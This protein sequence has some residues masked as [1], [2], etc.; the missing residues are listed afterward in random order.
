MLL[1]MAVL[2]KFFLVICLTKYSFAECPKSGTQ[3][4][5]PDVLNL[6]S[7][8]TGYE[9]W[10]EI[11]SE[12]GLV[13]LVKETYYEDN[14]KVEITVIKNGKETKI[15]HFISTGEIFMVSQEPCLTLPFDDK[16]KKMILENIYPARSLATELLVPL[17]GKIVSPAGLL[18]ALNTRK[19]GIF[20]EEKEEDKFYFCEDKYNVMVSFV[21]GNQPSYMTLEL[22]NRINQMTRI[23]VNYVLYQPRSEKSEFLTYPYQYNCAR[24]PTVDQPKFPEFPPFMP[25]KGD[26]YQYYMELEATYTKIINGREDSKSV[27]DRTRVALTEDNIGF[28]IL[29]LDSKL[30]RFVFDQNFKISYSIKDDLDWCS[31]A[32]LDAARYGSELRWPKFKVNFNLL[33]Y[34]LWEPSESSKINYFGQKMF[35]NKLV[36]I[37][38][39]EISSFY[40]FFKPAKAIYYFEVSNNRKKAPELIHI[41]P[42]TTDANVDQYLIELSIINF[43]ERIGDNYD[44]LDVS[45]CYQNSHEYSWVQVSFTDSPDKMQR[46]YHR[47]IEI[48]DSFRKHLHSYLEIPVIRV[49]EIQINFY[50]AELYIT[51]KLLER[52]DYSYTF[53]EV[54]K[55]RLSTYDSVLYTES[56]EECGQICLESEQKCDFSYCSDM[57]C[58]V[59]AAKDMEYPEVVFD[60]N[61]TTYMVRSGRKINKF[62][63]MSNSKLVLH[64]NK[65]LGG[66]FV[67]LDKDRLFAEEA[68][69]VNGPEDTGKTNQDNDRVHTINNEYK[70]VKKNKKIR[71]SNAINALGLS[72]KE[73]L[74]ECEDND[75]CNSIAYCSGGQDQCI[76]SNYHDKDLFGSRTQVDENCNIFTS[77]ENFFKIDF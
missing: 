21:A 64:I 59:Q 19:D 68:Y 31:G 56:S 67:E 69:L 52:P 33:R 49:P 34:E 77:K 24:L 9:S 20:L 7:S 40:S 48:I 42:L 2:I 54:K 11:I 43:E 55:Y 53:T 22:P 14:E 65:L 74:Q 45:P 23:R 26:D 46:W 63:E 38:V 57:K 37:F 75:E 36:D 47:D 28:E 17:F 50:G 61:C 72:Y 35:N 71:D 5:S 29:D 41:S 6:I 3:K 62:Y 51:M 70:L 32:K 66:L 44:L 18:I 73:C 25:H 4:N 15:F 39:R 10:A 30:Q 8:Q 12:G 1:R 58:L 16:S 13:A 60:A 76:Q 27:V